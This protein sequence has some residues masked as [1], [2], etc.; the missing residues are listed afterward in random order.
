MPEI[1]VRYKDKRTLEALRDFA[2]YF[3]YEI[4]STDS[5]DKKEKQIDL[6]GVTVIPA[7]S[8]V[9]ITELTD[10]FTGKNI[11]PTELR[12]EAWQRRK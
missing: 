5:L 2:K 7:D 9:D 1:I 8:S 11:N 4:S 10:I 12:N 3:D 6:N